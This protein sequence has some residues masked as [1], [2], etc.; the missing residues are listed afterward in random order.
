MEF[1][2]GKIYE[3]SNK[4][5]AIVDLLSA[6]NLIHDTLECKN[7]CS[8]KS[9]LNQLNDL[10]QSMGQ[11]E[12]VTTVDRLKFI[13]IATKNVS[14]FVTIEQLIKKFRQRIYTM[15]IDCLKTAFFYEY[16]KIKSYLK[17]VNKIEKFRGQLEVLE[18]NI[19]LIFLKKKIARVKKK[20]VQNNQQFLSR[21]REIYEELNCIQQHVDVIFEIDKF[22][23]MDKFFSVDLYFLKFEEL[24]KEVRDIERQ[25][26]D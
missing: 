14:V 1:F 18:K 8:V 9:F 26:A 16:E 12:A 3:V 20:M 15:E 22:S 19:F 5:Y 23:L 25:L 13:K 4:K 24:E 17:V 2:Y 21:L 10:V 6:R 11:Q 7:D